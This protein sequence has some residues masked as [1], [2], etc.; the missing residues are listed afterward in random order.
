MTATSNTA[1]TAFHQLAED[2]GAAGAATLGK[3][4]SA[5]LE[6]VSDTCSRSPPPTSRPTV[7]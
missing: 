3:A 1:A 7:G 2:T 4:G 6:N 5:A